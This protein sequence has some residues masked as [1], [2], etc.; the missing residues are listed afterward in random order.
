MSFREEFDKQ[1]ENF[2][3]KVWEGKDPTL[4]ELSA[5]VDS[6]VTKID[7]LDSDYRH[8]RA[9]MDERVEFS[10][11]VLRALK[12]IYQGRR[13]LGELFDGED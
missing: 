10:E 9:Q 5:A 4:Q 11:K 1:N 2:I 13:V 7:R 3:R 8:A 12:K 6:L